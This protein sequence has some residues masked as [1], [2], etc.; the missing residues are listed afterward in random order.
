MLLYC[1]Q[2][3]T[4]HG[5]DIDIPKV[6]KGEC[7]LCH[8]RLGPMNVMSEE[9]VEVLV[10]GIKT[11]IHEVAGFSIQEVKGFPKGIK[12]DTIEPQ[13]V[14]HRMVSPTCV[15]FFDAGKMVIA[16]PETGKRFKITF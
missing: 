7:G 12:I 10:N 15:V 1:D 4:K 9:D 3:G 11:D 6:Y 8:R 16:N 13:M 5:Y 14:N 2:C